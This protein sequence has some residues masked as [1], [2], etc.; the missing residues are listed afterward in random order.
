MLAMTL[1]SRLQALVRLCRRARTPLA[2]PLPWLLALPSRRAVSETSSVTA[3]L[4]SRE[5]AAHKAQVDR[6]D[7]SLIGM[8][9][10]AR[11]IALL[12]AIAPK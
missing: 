4:L 12:T 2:A 7:S 11:A 5:G 8:P 9:A 6:P 10:K 3:A 1:R